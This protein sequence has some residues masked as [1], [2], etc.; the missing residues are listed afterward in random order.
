MHFTSPAFVYA[1]PLTLEAFKHPLLLLYLQKVQ[2]FFCTH[3]A[4]L[5]NFKVMSFCLILCFTTLDSKLLVYSALYVCAWQICKRWGIQ[6]IR[7]ARKTLLNLEIISPKHFF[8][9]P[10]FVDTG[11]QD[12]KYVNTQGYNCSLWWLLWEKNHRGFNF[13][14]DSQKDLEAQ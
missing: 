2:S 13:R 7:L 10:A 4:R 6:L 9:V 14:W 8:E 12:T 3:S 11:V 5:W 1:S